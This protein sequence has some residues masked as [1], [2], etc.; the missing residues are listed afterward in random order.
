MAAAVSIYL[1]IVVIH[2]TLLVEE[3]Q[4]PPDQIADAIPKAR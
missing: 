4:I 1:G 3:E 2:I